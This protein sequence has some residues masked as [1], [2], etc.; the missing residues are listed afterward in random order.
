MVSQSLVANVVC[1]IKVVNLPT[2]ISERKLPLLFLGR[3][4]VERYDCG[5]ER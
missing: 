2:W 4:H 5:L 3:T 1:Q